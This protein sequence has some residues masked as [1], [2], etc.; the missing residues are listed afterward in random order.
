M[1]PL[2]GGTCSLIGTSTNL[3][4]DGLIRQSGF[5]GFDLFEIAAV[6]LPITFVGCVY[7]IL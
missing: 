5:P 2:W 4:V 7:L 3:I 6:G 1:H